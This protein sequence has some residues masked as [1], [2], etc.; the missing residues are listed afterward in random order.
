LSLS[1]FSSSFRFFFFLLPNPKRRLSLPSPQIFNRSCSFVDLSHS[2]LAGTIS[3]PLSLSRAISRDLT[4]SRDLARPHSL[5]V[6]FNLT[7]SLSDS[8]APETLEL[9]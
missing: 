9:S 4:L 1:V 2:P 3:P 5:S 6:S 7:L 8:T